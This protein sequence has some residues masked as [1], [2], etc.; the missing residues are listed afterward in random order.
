MQSLLMLPRHTTPHT[1]MRM[2]SETP[3]AKSDLTNLRRI[4]HSKAT[5][6]MNVSI[7][8]NLGAPEWCKCWPRLWNVER[9]IP[10]GAAAF[11]T[12]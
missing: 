2:F 7:I 11:T 1:S 3:T 8:I 6:Q 10:G 12:W 9:L 4:N 5:I